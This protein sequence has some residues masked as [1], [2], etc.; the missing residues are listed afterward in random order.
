MVIFKYNIYY[1]VMKYGDFKEWIIIL[2][3]IIDLVVV[4]FCLIF[5]KCEYLWCFGGIKVFFEN[6]FLFYLFRVKVFEWIY[7]L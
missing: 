3:R 6:G 1:F 2:I 4:S 7:C 5:V